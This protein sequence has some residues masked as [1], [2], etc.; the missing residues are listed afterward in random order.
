MTT[1]PAIPE[2]CAV[3]YKEWAGVCEALADGRQ[4]VL[5]RKGGIDE[6]P[7]GF[8]PEH[9]SF[10]LY[11]THVHQAQQG[12]RVPTATPPSFPTD[13]VGLETL[14][15][16]AEVAF[17]DREEILPALE[18]FHVWTEEAVS[19]RF[20]Y[21]RP[22][23]WLLTV[24]AFRRPEPWTV[25][26]TPEHAGCKTWVPLDSPPPAAGLVPVLDDEEFARRMVA[27]RAAT[28]GAP[29]DMPA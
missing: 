22:G 15:V 19:K 10:W 3:A 23:V 26:V 21:R 9:G 17:L 16:V 20:H 28:S 5:L 6:G 14:A 7:G 1:D 4:C 11:P 27:L 12:L 2:T 24:R 8:R 18:G 13:Q 29:G 25:E